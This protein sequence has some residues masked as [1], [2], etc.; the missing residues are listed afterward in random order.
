MSLRGAVI[1]AGLCAFAG[2]AAA[3]EIPYLSIQ[4]LE[5]GP[6]VCPGGLCQADGLAGFFAVLDE[7][8]AGRR[9]GPVRIVQFG[10]SHTAGGRITGRLRARLQERFGYGDAGNAP[11]VTLTEVG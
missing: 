11:G 10:D 5:A 8:E 1:A 3:Q 9:A 2:G 7:M 4:S 6:S